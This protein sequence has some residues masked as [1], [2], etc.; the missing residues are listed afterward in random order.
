MRTIIH[1][2]DLELGCMV[3]ALTSETLSLWDEKLLS[4][5]TTRSPYALRQKRK[6]QAKTITAMSITI[7]SDL[8]TKIFKKR[9]TTSGWRIRCTIFERLVLVPVMKRDIASTLARCLTDSKIDKK[10]ANIRNPQDFIS[11]PEIPEWKCYHTSIKFAPFEALYMR[12]CRSLVIWTEV[13][14]SQ[15]IRPEIMQETTEKIVQIKERLK[16]ARSRQKSYAD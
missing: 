5:L 1:P 3:F 10:K 6:T 15:L 12:K 11:N 4:T 8:K 14:E 2:M 13:G 16:T 9:R 7:H